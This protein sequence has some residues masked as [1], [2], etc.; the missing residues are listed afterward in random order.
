MFPSFNSR[1]ENNVRIRPRAVSL[2]IAMLCLLC[3]CAGV[4]GLKNS[5]T[6][7]SV[8]YPF[9]YRGP[10]LSSE[11][12]SEIV[13]FVQTIDGID[14]HVLR[15][16]VESRGQLEVQTGPKAGNPNGNVIHLRR[17]DGKW[18]V[19]DISKGSGF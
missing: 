1:P 9:E 13:Q 7:Y 10:F 17:G 16:S 18:T 12:T 6:T 11:E 14:H 8:N 3:G 2:L 5:P 19:V 4:H 15:I